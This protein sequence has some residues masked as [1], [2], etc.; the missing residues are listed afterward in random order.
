M[1]DPSALLA[2]VAAILRADPALRRLAPNWAAADARAHV[3][4]GQPPAAAVNA[5][6]TPCIVVALAQAAQP[7]VGQGHRR[8]AIATATVALR[9][10]A[11]ANACDVAAT[12]C[13]ALCDADQLGDPD[14]VLGFHIDVGA[15]ERLAGCEAITLSIAIRLLTQPG[16]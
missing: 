16:A 11:H 5:G 10:V 1:T 15:L 13:A 14:H 9:V 6:R 4:A 8:S 3:F 7:P 12:A 2:S